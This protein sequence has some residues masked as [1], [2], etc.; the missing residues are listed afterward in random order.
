MDVIP[1][2]VG[3]TY[4]AK[5]S[6]DPELIDI[7]EMKEDYWKRY[8]ETRDQTLATGI[9]KFKG[10]FYIVVENKTERLM[11]DINRNFFT[12]L[13][14][15]PA[16]RYC[17]TV[18]HYHQKTDALELLW[19]VPD[20][21]ASLFMYKYPLDVPEDQ[22]KLRSNVLDFFDGTLMNKS[23]ELN[24]ELDSNTEKTLELLEEI[25]G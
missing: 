20:R 23:N 22:H 9:G 15:C 17:Q 6:N 10:D 2:T 14:A 11:P 19:I 8:I 16:P 3:Q 4:Q 25:Y 5:H 24:K 21:I 13:S 7:D 1:K 12:T 18:Y